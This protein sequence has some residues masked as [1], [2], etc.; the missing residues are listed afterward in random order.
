MS[1]VRDISIRSKI[2]SAFSIVCFLSFILSLFTY[3]SLREIASEAEDVSVSALPS[4][5]HL[6]DARTDMTA[7][8]RADLAMLL[9]SQD[10]CRNHYGTLRQQALDGYRQAVRAYEPLINFSDE[11]AKYDEFTNAFNEYLQYSD[12][13]VGLITAGKTGDALDVLMSE[14]TTKVMERA[15]ASGGDEISSNVQEATDT[16]AN[17]IATTRIGSSGLTSWLPS[18]S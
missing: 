9:C 3:F 12:R 16:A 8:R 13:S 1:L 5:V 6:E 11:R 10:E 18:E 15:L 4:V 2:M 14:A 7:M 17:V